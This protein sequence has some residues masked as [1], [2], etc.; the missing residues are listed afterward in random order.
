MSSEVAEKVA[1]RIRYPSY[2]SLD[3]FID[4][5]WL[6]SLDG[7]VTDR[8]QRRVDQQQDIQFY[9]GPFTFAEKAPVKPGSKMVYLSQPKGEDDYYDLNNPDAW[10]AA[11][12]A[13][14]FSELMDFVR[15]LPFK[16]T[17]RMLIMYDPEGRAVTAHRDHVSCNLCHEFIW[18]RTNLRK[19]FYM[20]NENTGEKR[21]V[22]SHSAWF[23]SVNQFHGGDATGELAISIRVDGLFS[24]DFKATIPVPEYNLAS[25]PSFWACSAS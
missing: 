14:E 1:P 12:G 6:K 8:I 23:D 11:A 25:T 5:E 2:K 18:F 17:A 16:A 19:P 24:E 3:E 15:T 21:Y 13:T 4:V 9:T 22:T 20:L 7:Y 10:E